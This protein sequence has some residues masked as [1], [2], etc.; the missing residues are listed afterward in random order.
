MLNE[1]APVGKYEDLPLEEYTREELLS[2]KDKTQAEI[3]SIRS[4]LELQTARWLQEGISGDPSWTYRAKTAIRFKGLLDQRIGRELSRRKIE[5]H[6]SYLKAF[7]DAAYQY[8]PH[9]QFEAI[10]N[11]A[12]EV[13]NDI[14]HGT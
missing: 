1:K 13:V 12:K 6:S 5:R 7:M 2:L 8:L 10:N 9:D 11:I 4:Q 14:S 3:A